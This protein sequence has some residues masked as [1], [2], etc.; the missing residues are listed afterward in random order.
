MDKQRLQVEFSNEALDRLEMLQ[1]KLKLEKKA[2]VVRAA[3]KILD[4]VTHLTDYDKD[5]VVVIQ[6]KDGTELYRTG[7]GSLLK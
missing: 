5:S 4:W 1:D 7:V 3:L 6:K 2:D